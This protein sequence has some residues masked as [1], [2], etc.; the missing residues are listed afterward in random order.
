MQ[1]YPLVSPSQICI[2]QLTFS[3]LSRCIYSCQ[4]E[5]KDKLLE[6]RTKVLRPNF[7]FGGNLLC[8]FVIQIVGRIGNCTRV[9]WIANFTL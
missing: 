3:L 2:F 9:K 5:R 8:R 6:F 1:W 7:P 4:S